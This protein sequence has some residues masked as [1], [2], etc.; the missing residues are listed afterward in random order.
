MMPDMR[1]SM[2]MRMS[3]SFSMPL[4]SPS[5]SKQT[6]ISVRSRTN[7]IDPYILRTVVPNATRTISSEY[8]SAVS[9]L[10]SNST[11]DMLEYVT[12]LTQQQQRQQQ[13]NGSMNR[14][15]LVASGIVGVAILLAALATWMSRLLRLI[16]IKD[17]A[18]SVYKHVDDA[19]TVTSEQS[20]ADV[21]ITKVS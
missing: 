16:A 14:P 13:R 7:T 6:T 19:K 4:E 17:T 12:S 3:M 9:P 8:L 15:I 5:W 10:I 21:S 11:V 20:L 1:F 18:L 2:S